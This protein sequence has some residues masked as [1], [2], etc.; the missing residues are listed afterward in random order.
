MSFGGVVLHK[1]EMPCVTYTEYVVHTDRSC[2]NSFGLFQEISILIIQFF[3]TCR[4]P[5]YPNT[6]LHYSLSLLL[7]CVF[8]DHETTVTVLSCGRFSRVVFP[9]KNSMMTSK[10]KFG[11][12]SSWETVHS[13]QL[14]CPMSTVTWWKAA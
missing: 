10:K 1:L 6:T 14:T 5:S 13:C 2:I 9:I 4:I 3:V 7:S 12:R 8:S 11:M